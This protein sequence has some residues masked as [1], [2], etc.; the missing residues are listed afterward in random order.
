MQRF[1]SSAS[2]SKNTLSGSSRE[3][4]LIGYR[5]WHEVRKARGVLTPQPPKAMFYFV[6]EFRL[7]QGDFVNTLDTVVDMYFPGIKDDVV[8]LCLKGP[9]TN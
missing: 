1:I 5:F 9:T 4:E 8:N 7:Y 2:K 6:P 3:Q